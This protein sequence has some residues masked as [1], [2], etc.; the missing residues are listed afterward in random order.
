M[1]LSDTLYRER[2]FKADSLAKA[3]GS[4]IEGFWSTCEQRGAEIIETYQV[5]YGFSGGWLFMQ[6]VGLYIS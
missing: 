6:F 4:L 2:N 3:S 1:C 5:F